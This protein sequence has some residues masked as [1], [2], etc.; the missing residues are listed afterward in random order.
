MDHKRQSFFLHQIHQVVSYS[1]L[2]QLIY[3]V[4]PMND[5]LSR[6]HHDSEPMGVFAQLASDGRRHH[7]FKVLVGAAGISVV[8]A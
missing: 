6:D 4:V 1:F 7:H 5:F 2:I 8:V 3:T